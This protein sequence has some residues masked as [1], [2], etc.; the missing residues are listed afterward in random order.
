M[1]A[2]WLHPD[3]CIQET[4]HT[5]HYLDFMSHHPMAYKLVVVKTLHGRAEAICLDV[6]AKKQETRHI[7]QALINNGYNRGRDPA[8]PAPT[9]PAVHSPICA[10]SVRS[11][12][13]S[14]DSTRTDCLF[15]PQHYLQTTTS[16]TEGLDPHRKTGRSCVPGPM[17]KLPSFLCRPGRQVPG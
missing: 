12:L 10:W 8:T 5:D 4:T 9:R 15:P 3:N 16:E 11:S 1:G 6:T 13:A 2:R 7:R 14:P 17:Y